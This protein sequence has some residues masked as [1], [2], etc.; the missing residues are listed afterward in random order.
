VS[1]TRDAGGAH[2][3]EQRGQAGKPKALHR[4]P[5]DSFFVIASDSEAIQFYG[6]VLDCF[7]A[8]LVIGPATSGRT[9]WFLAM[10]DAFPLA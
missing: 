8:E 9:R 1:L 4:R 7:V 3:G 6:A 5:P 2:A 10:T